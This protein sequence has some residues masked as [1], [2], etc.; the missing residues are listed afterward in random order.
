M[1]K[2]L[3]LVLVFA[4]S[5]SVTQAAMAQDS[6]VVVFRRS[7]FTGS[8]LKP[9]I[10]V[11]GNEAARLGNGRYLSLQVGAGKHTFGSSAKK[12]APLEVDVKPNET[13]YLEMIIITG[14]NRGGRLIPV[15]QDDAMSALARLK[16]QDG[17]PIALAQTSTVPT[18]QPEP[19]PT[20]NAQA[21]P[22]PPPPQPATVTVKSTPPGADITVD[23]KFMGNTPSTIQLSPGDHVVEVEKE[24]LRPW[25]RGMTIT[26]GGN[27]TIDATLDK[28]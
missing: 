22:E 6:T 3:G 15:G 16:T 26:A 28:P 17:K 5:L 11:D 19:Q 27:I 25:Q 10:L 23:G 13:L 1:K 12:E 7:D 24:G 8:A 14:W 2:I 4:A 9:S 20:D 21:E 18:A